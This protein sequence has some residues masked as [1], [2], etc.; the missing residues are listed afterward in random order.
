MACPAC[1]NKNTIVVSSSKYYD[2]YKCT[3]CGNIYKV[4]K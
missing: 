2:E 4:K 1:G 3:E